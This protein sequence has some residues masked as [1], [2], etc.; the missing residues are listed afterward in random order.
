MS[1]SNTP[2]V[3]ASSTTCRTSPSPT[4]QSS[5]L[6]PGG[7]ELRAARKRKSNAPAA[8]LRRS[9][10]PRH[11]SSRPRYRASILGSPLAARTALLPREPGERVQGVRPEGMPVRAYRRAPVVR[12]D[13]RGLARVVGGVG[14][15]PAT[16]AR[17]ARGR[18]RPRCRTNLRSG[19]A[20]C[21]HP[22]PR[23]DRAACRIVR[24]IHK[25]KTVVPSK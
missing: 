18:L 5:P 12:T 17:S 1:P 8:P 10:D 22:R 14:R 11:A 19:L 4:T 20:F 24:E 23:C 9:P 15:R 25:R 7:P 13:A 16:P 3:A 2:A 6:R 21:L